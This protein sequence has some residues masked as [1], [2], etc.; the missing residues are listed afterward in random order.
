LKSYQELRLIFI[1][2]RFS[3]LERPRMRRTNID[4]S[5]DV[6]L[7]YFPLDTWVFISITENL[8]ILIDIRWRPDLRVN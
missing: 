1:K 3:I 4:R 2:I 8:G 5:L 6:M 7:D